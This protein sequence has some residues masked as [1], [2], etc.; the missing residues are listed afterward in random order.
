MPPLML[1]RHANYSNKRLVSM[2]NLGA[3][4]VPVMVMGISRPAPLRFKRLSKG[5]RRVRFHP[6]VIWE[7]VAWV[8][9]VPWKLKAWPSRE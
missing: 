4:F 8:R 2:P 5:R 7:A 6:V 1:V 3:D 9:M